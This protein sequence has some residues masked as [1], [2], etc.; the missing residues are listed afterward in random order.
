[1]YMYNGNLVNKEL[2]LGYQ[3]GYG[4]FETIKVLNGKLI[5]FK[6]HT[7]RLFEGCSKLEINFK[8]TLN[9]L[10]HISKNFLNK[11]NFKNGSLKLIVS[12]N[13]D[14]S[15]LLITLN[16]KIYTKSQYEKGFKIKISS[17]KKS[18]T[19]ILS[20]IKSLNYMEN[21]YC[22][23]KAKAAGYDETI[24]LNSKNYIC[25]G[26]ISNIFFI[27]NKKLYTP[28][29]KNGL[30]NGIIRSK[31]IEICR[32]NSIDITE[33]NYTLEDLLKADEIFLT[34]SLMGV[35]PVLKVNNVNFKNFTEYN[36]FK[37]KIKLY[38]SLNENFGGLNNG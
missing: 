33:G 17:I 13:K 25:E 16:N 15:D 12:K 5:F 23:N 24:F 34:N 3:Y 26:T 29:L 28:S 10:F 22:L 31:I 38:E 6:E 27:K 7:E 21:I 9:E 36:F 37:N 1:M 30:L 8:Y 20:K 19:S 35:M 2:S 11:T 18:E 14:S 4:V 32:Q